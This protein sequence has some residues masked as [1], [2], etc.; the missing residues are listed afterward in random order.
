MAFDHMGKYFRLI[1][2]MHRLVAAALF[3]GALLVGLPHAWCQPV[4]I[5]LLTDKTGPFASAGEQI[6][7]GAH[8]AV[9]DIPSSGPAAID[10]VEWDSQSQGSAAGSAAGRA[11]EKLIQLDGVRAVIVGPESGTI[12]AVDGMTARLKIP[13]LS[14]GLLSRPLTNP[15]AVNLGDTL[16]HMMAYA[17]AYARN[18]N[19]AQ[20]PRID[21]MNEGIFG[22]TLRKVAADTQTAMMSP[23]HLSA[24]SIIFS[25]DK[26]GQAIADQIQI[27]PSSVVIGGPILRGTADGLIPKLPNNVKLVAF[28]LRDPVLEGI[29]NLPTSLTAG[30]DAHRPFAYYGYAAVQIFRAALAKPGGVASVLRSD[31]YQTA[32]GAVRFLQSDGE[33]FQPGLAV[34]V[35][36]PGGILSFCPSCSTLTDNCQTGCK[37]QDG[38]C[39]QDCCTGH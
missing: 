26:S 22:E 31:S 20:M 6:S 1:I 14:I 37:C 23:F 39:S 3:F 35:L 33:R 4:K 24:P 5:G 34:Y 27:P 29:A 2:A 11:A 36:S 13:M 8:A 9:A 18:T 12:L 21:L 10:L 32:V 16:G 15:F 25:F 7:R 38:S 19:P 28:D 30:Q 17:I